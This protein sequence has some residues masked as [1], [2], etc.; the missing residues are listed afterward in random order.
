[1]GRIW[2]KLGIVSV[3]LLLIFVKSVS[4]ATEIGEITATYDTVDAMKA[5]VLN[6]KEG[7]LV[8]TNGYYEENDKG[9][10]VYSI[11]SSANEEANE[12]N[13]ITLN[14]ALLAVL[15]IENNTVNIKQYG[16]KGNGQ[17]DDHAAIELAVTSGAEIVCFEPG[18]YKCTD[19]L[20]F[21]GISDITIEG[22]G[23]VIFTD[24]DYRKTL[25]WKEHFIRF[26]G[27]NAKKAENITIRDLA[28]ETRGIYKEEIGQKYKNQI[29]FLYVDGVLVQRCQFYISEK[30]P[31]NSEEG[32]I[33]A[34]AKTLEYSCFDL[35]TGWENVTVRDCQ[36]INEAGAYYGVCVQFRDIWNAGGQNAEF[37]NNYC[38]SNSKDEIVAIFSGESANSYIKNVT[39]HNNEIEA[40]KTPYYDRNLCMTVGYD[41]SNCCDN[42]QIYSNK[43]TGVCDWALFGMGKTLSNSSIKDNEIICKTSNGE[44]KV[45]I[46]R[47]SATDTGNGYSNTFSG[48]SIYIPTY[49]GN[50]LQSVFSA[51]GNFIDN[52]I[53]S[54]ETIYA[55]FAGDG[56]Y[57]NNSIQ[58][59]ADVSFI[60]KIAKDI[61]N[62]QIQIKGNLSVGFEFYETI[63]KKKMEISGNSIEIAGT[64]AGTFLMLNGTT[65]SGYPLIMRKNKIDAPNCGDKATLIYVQLKDDTPQTIYLVDNEFGPYEIIRQWGNADGVTHLVS[66]ELPKEETFDEEKDSNKNNQSDKNAESEE[67]TEETGSES[68]TE[69][70]GEEMPTEETGS[71]DGENKAVKKDTQVEKLAISG[72]SYKIAA[73]KKIRL[74]LKVLPA[75]AANKSVIWQSSNRKYATVNSAGKVN[76]KKAGKGKTV[77][78]TVQ[79]K[80]GSG[81]KASYKIKIM[82]N[83]VTSVKIKKAPKTMKVG[84]TRKLT[85]KVKTNGKYVN[86][87]IK[88]TTSNKKYA[89]V[90]AKGK[91][92]AKKAGKNKTVTITAMS[93]D[94]TNKKARVKIKIR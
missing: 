38:Y 71:T 76:T 35:Y 74:N 92:T 30:F 77:T 23:A 40:D 31:Q 20:V 82:K 45:G 3:F 5:D 79:A 91:V 32:T 69:D 54:E 80:D 86:K 66:A 60:G 83:A 46:V 52:K 47:S 16:A 6:L 19:E 50:G 18:E 90:S 72:I 89:T 59:N 75:Y 13:I 70:T 78:I 94:G 41:V 2:K 58:V 84:E 33:P 17:E 62:N 7:D 1:M 87:K 53:I 67:G 43:I 34:G 88:W 55:I 10:A 68:S 36:L 15:K 64:N 73:G 81:K 51:G 65:V 37:Y 8:K 26:V 21:Y 11:R 63:L 85:V 49:Q 9:G 28:V 42:I 12:R 14:D 56:H 39:I 24:D 4:S 61:Q 29:A 93:T 48:N 27:N 57:E 25:E 22:N 44:K